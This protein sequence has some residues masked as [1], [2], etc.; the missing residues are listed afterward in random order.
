MSEVVSEQRFK[1]KAVCTRDVHQNGAF[2][3]RLRKGL[4]FEKR[5]LLWSCLD[6][7]VSGW[8]I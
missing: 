8:D 4:C 1:G 2:I 5:I 7:F 3:A 6:Q